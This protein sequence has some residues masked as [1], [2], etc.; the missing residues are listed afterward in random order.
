[1]IIGL[2]L[3]LSVCSGSERVIAGFAGAHT[4]G[5]FD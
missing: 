3:V 4:H 2:S 1:M 5:L